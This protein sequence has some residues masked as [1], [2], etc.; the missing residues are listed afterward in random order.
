MVSRVSALATLAAMERDPVRQSDRFNRFCD[1]VL[2]P[3]VYPATAPLSVESWRCADPVGYRAAVE[4]PFERVG[5][6]WEW[7]PVWSTCWFRL[8][9]SVPGEFAGRETVFRFDSGVEAQLWRDGRPVQGFDVNRDAA[10]LTGSAEGGES[11]ELHVEAACNH[12]FGVGQ[13]PWDPPDAARRWRGER[14]ARLERAEL[15]VFDRGAWE[16]AVAFRFASLL[17]R[18]L[19]EESARAG[20][21]IEGLGRVARM[22]DARGVPACADAAVEELRGLLGERAP[23]SATIC[24]AVGHAH[25]DT[26]WLWPVR[27]TRRKCVRSFSNVLRLMERFE[28]FRFLCSQA[29]Q[30]AFIERD[31]PELFEEIRARVAEGRW[32]A[33]GA[34]WVEPDANCPSGES[35]VRQIVHGCGYWREKFGGDGAQRF[36]YL[37]DTFGFPASLPQIIAAAGLDTFITNKLAWNA[38]NRYPHTSFL[39][40]GIDGTELLTHFTPGADY[41]AV[42]TPLELRRGESRH[43][44]K[45]RGSTEGPAR[46]LQPFG[47][48]DGGGGPTARSIEYACLASDCDGLPRTRL[49][50]TDEFCGA[51][52]ADFA[53][54]RERGVSPPVW[55]GELYLDLHRG[56]LTTQ[57]WLKRANRRAEGMLR[58]A[59]ATLALGPGGMAEPDPQQADMLDEAWKLLLL[60][61]FHD[62]LPGSSIGW[63]Y[64]DAR[65]DFERINAL[66]AP[67]LASGLDRWAKTM[68]GAIVCNPSSGPRSGVVDLDSG[69]RFVRDVP[70]L[71]ASGLPDAG[72][73][74]EAVHVEGGRTLANG[75]IR[76]RIDD[77]GQIASLVHEGTG[78]EACAGAAI[79]RLEVFE[80]LP[81]MW[82]AWDIDPEAEEKPLDVVGRPDSIDVVEEGPHRCAIRVRR[83][84]GEGSQ[85]EQTYVLEAESPRI[86]VRTRVEWHE[87]HRLLRASFP[88][89][90]RSTRATYEIQFGH[91]ERP[92]HRNTEWDRAKFEV[93]AHR[94]MDLSEPGFGVALLNDSK[95]GH[96]CHGSVM[97][98]SLLRSPTWP[99]PD[100]D[101]GTH[102]FV[103]SL[104][105]HGGDWRAAGVHR[106]AEALNAPLVVHGGGVAG[107]D[108]SGRNGAWSPFRISCD[109]GAGVEIAAVKPAEDGRGIVVRLVE[110]LGGRGRVTLAWSLPVARVEPVDLLERPTGREGCVH[111]PEG[112]ETGVSIGPFEIVTLRVVSGS[113]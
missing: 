18:E 11:V 111:R 22:I 77:D 34:M 87:E 98:L 92:T 69:P 46:W 13:F 72:A 5:I 54:M 79:N 42:N 31:S 7:G 29:Q 53:A 60:N 50:R 83:S 48:G 33:G 30:Y 66:A 27:E 101:R 91:I 52:H 8:R 25:I 59:E 38:V 61:Q 62:I 24:H 17:L 55:D 45:H 32:E 10:L 12:P 74:F 104:M 58:L 36:V 113:E 68:G 109:G 28:G 81:R 2:E 21:L 106:E 80:D 63:V 56:T 49:G 99:D 110:V 9:G 20:R 97:G 67:V 76:V 37:P 6:G 1:A 75:R 100:A 96:S 86:D 105:P 89:D 102:E 3:A 35:L 90:V 26:A 95:Y 85:I 103:Y 107:G 40:R 71:G 78:R 51:L 84:V 93:C 15:A 82:D 70:A 64:E 65:R 19:A 73:P 14:P 112:D 4:A 39:W 108:G 16:L 47:Y 23:G 94:W 44:S 88:V 41:N 43:A 57:A